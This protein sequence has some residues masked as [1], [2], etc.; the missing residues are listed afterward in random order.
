[1]SS[2]SAPPNEL[3]VPFQVTVDR[4]SASVNTSVGFD[5]P[6]GRSGMT[7]SI[8]LSYGS[9]RRQGCFGRGWFLTGLIVI[10]LDSEDGLPRYDGS[11][12]YS[13][14]LGGSLVRVRNP[15]DGSPVT[16]RSGSF[17][18]ERYRAQIDDSM[19]RFERWIQEPTGAVHWR[20]RDA[21][22]TLT[23]YGCDPSGASRIA[24]PAARER[25]FQ[26]LPELQISVRGDAIRYQYA[27][28]DLR[29]GAGTRLADQSRRECLAQRYLKRIS[30]ANTAAVDLDGPELSADQW[31]FH[32]VFDYGDH[33][34][35]TPQLNPDRD[36]L[37]R[38]DPFSVGIPGFELRSWRLCQRLL[39]FHRFAELGDDPVLTQSYQFDY[40][41]RESGSLLTSI[42]KSG[43]RTEDGATVSKPVPQ[44]SFSYTSREPLQGFAPA[45]EQLQSMAP[46][47]LSTGTT[48]LVD[49]MGE[50][51]PGIL[52]DDPTGW[53]FQRNLGNGSFA[54]PRSV[55]TRPSHSLRSVTL[56]DFD[57]D[58]NMDAVV[59]AGN[60]AGFYQFDRDSQEWS[61]FQ[62][63]AEMPHTGDLRAVERL[64]L[65]GDGRADLLSRDGDT[66][67]FYESRGTL[68]YASERR[69]VRLPTS[70]AD[71]PMGPPP[72]ATDTEVNYRFADMTGDGL[73]DQVLIR[74]RLVAYWPNLGQG[75]FGPPVVMEDSPVLEVGGR[76][77]MNRV[78][79]ADLDGSGTA[80]LVFLGEGEIW[81]WTN[82]AGNRFTESRKLSGLPMIDADSV[83]E[84]LDINGD[85]RQSLV[86]TEDRPGTYAAFQSLYL[87][88]PTPPGLMREVS[89]GMG[90]RDRI[91]YGYS[92][93]HYLRDM[94]GVRAWS[95]L[96]PGHLVVANRIESADLVGGTVAITDL[97]YRNGAFD[98]CMRTFAGFGE[99]DVSNAEFVQAD[100]DP[101]PTCTPALMRTFF[102]QGMDDVP[103]ERFWSGDP[104]AVQVPPFA[105]EEGTAGLDSE[106]WRDARACL[107]GRVLREESYAVGSDGPQPAP[108][109]VSQRGYAV[110][111]LQAAVP[112]PPMAERRRAGEK[113]VFYPD[114][115]ETAQ[116]VYEGVDDDPRMSHGFVLE[117]DEW[118]GVRLAAQLFYPRRADKPLD[119]PA[120]ARLICQLKRRTLLHVSEDDQLALNLEVAQEEFVVPG[121]SLP[122][123]GWFLYSEFS[124]AVSSALASPLRHDQPPVPGRA[125]RTNWTHSLY[126]NQAGTGADAFGAAAQP[127]RLHHTEAAVFSEDFALANYGPGIGSR[128]VGLGFVARNE[129]WWRASET[130]T[131][132]GADKFYRAMGH[133]LSGAQAV[134][135]D[136]DDAALFATRVTDA[137]GAVSRS[138][139]DYQALAVRRSESTTGA[140]SETAYDALGMPVR[141]TYGGSV[142]D[143]SGT[144]REYGFDPLEDV[145][146]PA[147]NLSAALADPGGTLAGAS[148]LL[149]YDL[150]AFQ[151][152][153]TPISE[154]SILAAGL[155]HDGKGG[156]QP[157]GAPRVEVSYFSGFGQPIATKRRV[158]GGLA[159]HRDAADDIV[160]DVSGEPELQVAAIRWSSSGWVAW[161]AK[162]EPVRSYEPYF[163][164]RPDY[165]DD[166]T[167]QQLGTASVVFHD[168][169][170]RVVQSLAPDGSMERSEYGAWIERH[171][172]GNDTVEISDWR[173][174]R[175][176]LPATHPERRALDGTFPHA[177]TPVE[178]VFDCAGRQVRIRE[179][180][181]LGGERVIQTVYLDTDEVDYNVDARGIVTSRSVYDMLGRKVSEIFADAGETRVLFDARDNPVEVIA[182]NN[183][184][185]ITTYDALDRPVA[186]DIDTGGSMRRIETLRYADDP[187]DA[188]AVSRNLLGLAVEA[189][190]EAGV[191]RILDATPNGQVTRSSLQ[192]VADIDTPVDWNSTVTLS[193]EIYESAVEFDAQARPILERRPVGTTLRA[194][195]TDGGALAALH[196]SDLA[197][198]FAETTVLKDATY[199]VT[200]HRET[201]TLGN[202]VSL[203]RT[204][205]RETLRVRRIEARR[206]AMGGRAPLLQD[207]NYSY[208]P[209]GN[210]TACLDGA[211][212]V[213]P[214]A[215]SA[216]FAA[217]PAASA[218]RYYSYDAFYRLT[219]CEGRAHIALTGGP[220]HQA[221]IPLSDGTGTERFTQTYTYDATDNLQ[222]LRHSGVVSN[223]TNDFWVD[224]MSNRSRPALTP[225]GLPVATPAADFAP[226]GELRQMDHIAALSWRHDQR[227][228]RAVIV[229]RSASGRPDDDEVYIY[230]GAGNRIRRVTRRLLGSG[231]VER[232][233][234]IYLAGC[235]IRRVYIGPSLILDRQ[236]TRVSDGFN[237]FVEIHVWQRDNFARETDDISKVRMLYT[238]GDHLGSAMLRLDESAR[239]ISYEEYLPFGGRAFAAGDNAR[240]VALKSYGFAGK[241]RDAATSLH[242]FSQRYYA[243]W[244]C[245]WISPDPNG[246]EDGPN[247]FIY[248]QNS[249]V[250]FY[251]PNGLETA[252][253][254]ERGRVSRVAASGS[255]PQP[256]IDALRALPRA[257]QQ[258]LLRLAAAGNFAYVLDPDGTVHFGTI[259]E[260]N[261]ILEAALAAGED[262]IIR[263]RPNGESDDPDAESG[264]GGAEQS[265]TESEQEQLLPEPGA[266][267]G[268]GRS[269]PGAD[270][271]SVPGAGARAG[272]GGEQEAERP[273]PGG[274]PGPR[275]GSGEGTTPGSGAGEGPGEGS[276]ATPGSDRSGAGG[277]GTSSDPAARGRG[278]SGSGMGAGTGDPARPGGGSGRHPGQAPPRPGTGP[279]GGTGGRQGDRTSGAPGGVRGG[280]GD[281]PG[282]TGTVPG[283]APGG[284]GDTPGGGP[285]GREG[286]V[287]GGSRNGSEQGDVPPPGTDPHSGTGG[288]RI[289][290]H[291]VRPPEGGR[292]GGT[293]AQRSSEGSANG[294]RQPG[295]SSDRRG[296][297]GSQ[298]SPTVMDYVTHVAGWWNLQFSSQPGG[299]SG[300]IPGGMGSHNL[301][302]WG[303]G[304]YVALTVL[305]IVLTVISLGGLAAI[306]AG[307]RSILEAGI[308]GIAAAG[309]R[310][311]SALSL[312]NLRGLA[313]LSIR[314]FS[315]WDSHLFRWLAMDIR[316]HGRFYQWMVRR[317]GW[318]A[319]L[320]NNPVSR[321]FLYGVNR[322]AQAT[323]RGA[324]RFLGFWPYRPT[325]IINRGR[326]VNWLDNFLHEG[327][328]GAA[329]LL[330]WPVKQLM[331][332]RVAGRPVFAVVQYLNEVGAYTLG[333]L[334]T[335]RL[336]ALP[337][338][339]FHAA[340]STYMYYFNIGGHA[341][342]R[343][344]VGWSAAGLGVLGGAAYGIYRYFSG[345]EEAPAEGA[346]P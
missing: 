340:A 261:A 314:E 311:A 116:A 61:S 345:E 222:R 257:R 212:D 58:G 207:L 134:R 232:S 28:E 178:C 159:I 216:F 215:A 106:S 254:P 169:A 291:D 323:A 129:H 35:D 91:Y 262:V 21:A 131:Y 51:L 197:G 132:Y 50:G 3:A 346:T 27:A 263:V 265:E 107:R 315:I 230:D 295:Q 121:L 305:D 297:G 195:Y 109:Q 203:K 268:E 32:A 123:R 228:S 82:A 344:A 298:Q 69:R 143:D 85:G 247:L 240:E 151:R 219:G 246:D 306:K 194:D 24:D 200:G 275:Q 284:T 267:G 108:L 13:S 29:G 236:V 283:G 148:Q 242:Y 90:R 184:R 171:Y 152:D 327:F 57:G 317:G 218:A 190:D 238:L 234:V 64:D 70:C 271:P 250:T 310:I 272:P 191:H 18:I 336:H 343:Q 276:G 326:G 260:M 321:W 17:R 235:E 320:V 150:E 167:L 304:A 333:R 45:P 55:M 53:F 303:Q 181:G 31:A 193:P 26:W 221:F 19:I 22:D 160:L 113:A 177:D 202:G 313:Q 278:D 270:T 290:P 249:P 325:N 81:I 322:G 39:V 12:G 118:S 241:E 72:L 287:E 46:A 73:P 183:T 34:S 248:C 180:D 14:T 146:A 67:T 339:P 206:S 1:M 309:R 52:F 300:G 252:R 293:S 312:R 187:L 97:A 214:G 102:D 68:G 335:L 285:G 189:H 141:A 44:L 286:G 328:H 147:P 88:P 2:A 264:A 156:S 330:A 75:R 124:A 117:R 274:Q 186:V 65:T 179:E 280:R 80:D 25:V 337:M 127:A 170:G 41:P 237:D 334:G 217:A 4:F 213:P 144:A 56:D 9:A 244:L 128:L 324:R 331:N 48:R 245:R 86:W 110:R 292:A 33:D 294:N 96:L 37:A 99:V 201:A 111:L 101:L 120:Q 196:V 239:I 182:A 258:E 139:I 20:S 168:A 30:W 105:I 301:G 92:A 223:W 220:N 40:D 115:R 11:D 84:V 6:E 226:S 93:Q 138:V 279:G 277:G 288:T 319:R 341:L 77:A 338:V 38:Q 256:V 54:G 210:V 36:W 289:A 78:L 233:E 307:I 329:N 157:P 251:D 23:I 98:S 161:N 211:H 342:A 10:G 299:H 149:I 155:T 94:G 259:A 153:G 59:M 165:E 126:W 204:Y 243:S 112:K 273:V 308:R 16:R 302:G 66:L 229:D 137:M 47:G 7:P 74:S 162:G 103:V 71:G 188:E 173:L 122:A 266:T 176:I 104:A 154:V 172:D 95:T 205:D 175:E 87:S 114:E 136:Y 140:W 225:D 133:E 15:A 316:L 142:V 282:A 135:V 185:K 199:S 5:L 119:D 269:Q 60:G 158:E 209:A 198:Q 255:F 296:P 332:R 227:L 163:S 63:F 125:Q 49:L 145:P 253:R 43:H 100:S 79:L 208:D 83:L 89:D 42:V 62:P 166:A 130:F 231:D 174:S 224:P 8:G 164:D 76:F 318:S 281:T 192:L